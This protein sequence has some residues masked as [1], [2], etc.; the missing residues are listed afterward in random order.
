[1]KLRR[2]TV[3]NSENIFEVRE[4]R[5]KVNIFFGVG[6]I[7]KVDEIAREMKERQIHS[8]L[9]VTGHGSYRSTGAWDRIETALKREG[10]AFRLY[11]GVTPNP[12][13][14]QV[15]EALAIGREVNAGA[16]IAIGGGSPIDAGKAVAA[17]LAYPGETARKLC[18]F[19]F[20]PE[21]ALPLLAVNLTHGTGT[22]ADRFSVITVPE[23]EHKPA[24]AYECMYPTWAIDDPAL[25][26]GLSEKQTRFVSIDAVNHVIEAATSKAASPFSILLARET[27]RQVARFLPEA[28]KD[29]SSLR[30]RYYLLYAS[31]IAGIAFDNG[32]LH[33]THALEHPLSAVNPDL[34]H[35]MGLAILLPAVVKQIYPEK[36]EVLADILSPIA[37]GLTGKPGEALSAA[38][39]VE[40][41]LFSCGATEKLADGGFSE[42]DIPKLAELTLS[43]PSLSTLLDMAPVE[44]SREIVEAIYRDSFRPME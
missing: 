3:M 19:E 37:P 40:R 10:I 4:I 44:S 15:D 12:T 11:N 35:G 30:A 29:P 20:A 23:K 33:F 1:M 18:S 5:C 13:A 31:M 7:A 39:A 28:L 34:T 43:T 8:V 24:L 41:W 42:N 9:V 22:E 21:R 16:V 2:N 38:K 25:M 36:G 26:T 32:L 17:L 6:A 14:D 27:I